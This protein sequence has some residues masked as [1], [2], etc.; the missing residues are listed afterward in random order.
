MD[1]IICAN[2]FFSN[3]QLGFFTSAVAG[4]SIPI[5]IFTLS[6]GVL[7]EVP[8]FRRELLPDR[9][10]PPSGTKLPCSPG[11]RTKLNQRRQGPRINVK[12]QQQ[13]VLSKYLASVINVMF[14]RYL[15]SHATFCT[16]VPK[17]LIRVFHTLSFFGCIYRTRS[18]ACYLP[19]RFA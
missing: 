4:N 19:Y 7:L 12:Q 5:S 15:T 17:R 18:A 13:R 2:I 9:A 8:Y 11:E 10:L 1:W 3:A 14:S 6:A 16:F